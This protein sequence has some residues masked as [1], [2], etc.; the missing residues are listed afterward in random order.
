[1]LCEIRNY[2]RIN[3]VVLVKALNDIVLQY[4]SQYR[5]TLLVTLHIR[6]GRIPAAGWW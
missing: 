1:M 2:V 3:R 4:D 5:S 6:S